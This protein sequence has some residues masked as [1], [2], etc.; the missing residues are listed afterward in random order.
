M[1]KKHR[2]DKGKMTKMVE[3]WT[4]CVGENWRVYFWIKKKNECL[5]NWKKKLF[6]IAN[7]LAKMFIRKFE[8]KNSSISFKSSTKTLVDTGIKAH[9]KQVNDR[10][11][12][13]SANEREKERER[14]REIES[15]NE[16]ICKREKFDETEK[17]MN[18][19]FPTPVLYITIL[20]INY[21]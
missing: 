3:Q 11:M 6:I 18:P 8:R 14:A 16:R 17:K 13:G 19:R 21:Y 1:S 2:G 4:N 7:E 5:E 10:S 20:N 12:H 9:T 15:L